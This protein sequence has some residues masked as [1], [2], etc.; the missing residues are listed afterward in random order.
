MKRRKSSVEEEKRSRL[1]QN[2]KPTH[3]TQKPKGQIMDQPFN[4]NSNFNKFS[5]EHT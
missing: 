2:Q 5:K 1:I 3:T 4:I